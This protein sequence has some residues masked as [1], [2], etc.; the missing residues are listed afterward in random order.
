MDQEWFD[1]ENKT[2]TLDFLQDG[3]ENVTWEYWCQRL[4]RVQGNRP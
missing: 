2:T 4:R 3:K 1:P